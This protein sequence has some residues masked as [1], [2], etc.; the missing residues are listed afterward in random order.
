M[1][2]GRRLGEGRKEEE[3]EGEREKGREE[4][5]KEDVIVSYVVILL[6]NKY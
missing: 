1:K 3:K 4:R 6:Y 2:E 5:R